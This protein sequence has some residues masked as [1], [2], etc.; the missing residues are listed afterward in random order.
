MSR[1]RDR[2]MPWWAAIVLAV[3]MV[4]GMRGAFFAAAAVKASA[5]GISLREAAELA[6]RDLLT[7]GLAQAAGVSVAVFVGVR[8]F[9]PDARLRDAVRLA[10]V[11]LGVVGLAAIAGLGLQ[12]PLAEVK[13]L[14]MDFVPSVFGQ[15]L[16]R[17]HELQRA[18]SPGTLGGTIVVVV[19]AVL[20]AATSEELFFRGLLL[21]SL[22]TRH[23]TVLAIGLTSFL[24]GA[25]HLDPGSA[26][27]ATL[28]GVL[29]GIVAVRTGSTIPA[30][31]MH[32]A[33]NAV[34][35]MLPESILPIPGFNVVSERVYHLPLLWLLGGALV[36]AAALFGLARL[37]DADAEGGDR[38]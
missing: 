4:A 8:W 27:A 28:A 7:V 5:R 38:P 6:A 12:F 22:R 35:V 23:G 14:L 10:P 37:A 9:F 34:P 36:C 3:L 30:V 33:V 20:I 29:L 18:I 25:V 13:N 1:S 2:D 17:Q 31:V 15:T 11:S 32:A 26:I 16:E 24:F 21:P 19:S